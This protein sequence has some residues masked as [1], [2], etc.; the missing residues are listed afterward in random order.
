[1]GQEKKRSRT[2]EQL[3]LDLLLLRPSRTEKQAG[4]LRVDSNMDERDAC[5]AMVPLP[6]CGT[7]LLLSLLNSG[8]R[9]R[10]Q[11][12]KAGQSD[13]ATCRGQE[14]GGSS[15]GAAAYCQ[16]GRARAQT[17]LR[18]CYAESLVAPS[19]RSVAQRQCRAHT[20]TQPDSAYSN[21]C[22]HRWV[23]ARGGFGLRPV[24]ALRPF[25]PQGLSGRATDAPAL[26]PAGA[27]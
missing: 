20:T 22:S 21:A 26:L 17:S 16:G 12:K 27:W 3:K 10:R 15:R 18:C 23:A 11:T 24:W 5:A 4:T 25:P 14:A 2:L 8:R 13:Q 7:S 9:R 19:S 6:P 1:V